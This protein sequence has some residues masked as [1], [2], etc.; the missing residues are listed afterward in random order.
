V[1][2]EAGVAQYLLEE[3]SRDVGGNLP[4]DIF[5][6]SSAGASNACFLAAFADQPVTRGRQLVKQ[7]LDLKLIDLVHIRAVRHILDF[8]VGRLARSRARQ[9]RAGGVL[10]ASK[11]QH[12][13]RSNIPFAQIGEHVRA[14]LLRAV[15]VSTT[16]VGSGRTVVFYQR[17]SDRPEPPVMEP[18]LSG[19][20]VVLRPEHA[21]AS[22]A[23]PFLFP[24]VPIDGQLYTDGALRPTSS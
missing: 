19:R 22:A 3:V 8:L 1:A 4:I 7:W 13:V 20:S 12:V 23:I 15:T 24:A 9:R 2:Y 5:C 6:G 17:E 21:L 18:M 10:D 14:G 11:L 16:L